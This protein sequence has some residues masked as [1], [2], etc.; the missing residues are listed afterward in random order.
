MRPQYLGLAF[1]V[2]VCISSSASADDPLGGIYSPSS[3]TLYAGHNIQ[4]SGWVS[5]MALENG[6]TLTVD[7]FFNK[8]PE[9]GGNGVSYIDIPLVRD[10]SW[11]AYD[12]YPV[13]AGDYIGGHWYVY[14][15]IDYHLVEW[16]TGTVVSGE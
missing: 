2:A 9:I 6:A 5:A 7:I 3:G 1:L 11:Y 13:P 8:N 16:T 4:P 10:P 14:F 15:Y 12:D